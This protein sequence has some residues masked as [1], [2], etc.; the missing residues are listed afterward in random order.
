VDALALLWR[1]SVWGQADTNRLTARE[2]S[3]EKCQLTELAPAAC[4][5]P[6]SAVRP[7]ARLRA[8]RFGEVRRSFSGGGNRIRDAAMPT[9]RLSG[10]RVAT[11]TRYVPIA[12][13]LA[14]VSVRRHY[15]SPCK[16]SFALSVQDA[17]ASRCDGTAASRCDL[18]RVGVNTRRGHAARR[19]RA[20]MPSTPRPRLKDTAVRRSFT[21][22]RKQEIG[23][24]ILPRLF[25]PCVFEA[26]SQYRRF[27]PV[28][29]VAAN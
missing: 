21:R 26:T 2:D 22:R 19:T 13:S 20:S 10:M 27:E 15:R 16:G 9:Q 25:R 8:K 14:L 29:H 12:S 3:G 4:T 1:E 23:E 5:R 18:S 24:A 28:A 11:A 17:T 7:P 6:R